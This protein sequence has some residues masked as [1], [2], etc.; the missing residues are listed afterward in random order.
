MSLIPE[1][2]L[3]LSTA[4]F[5]FVLSLSTFVTTISAETISNGMDNPIFS[6]QSL[7]LIAP[8]S[9]SIAKLIPVAKIFLRD[10]I[11]NLTV[12]PFAKYFVFD[13]S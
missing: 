8:V 4:I 9:E 11:V 2:S 1:L 5:K 10:L 12:I 13:D 3:L 6:S 7:G